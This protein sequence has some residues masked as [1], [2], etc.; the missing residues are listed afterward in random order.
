MGIESSCKEKVR[1][2]NVDKDNQNKSKHNMD[3]KI[4][5]KGPSIGSFGGEKPSLC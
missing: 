3:I 5:P 2:R 1:K 4:S